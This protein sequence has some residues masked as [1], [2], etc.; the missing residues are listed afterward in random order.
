MDDSGKTI[1][2]NICFVYNTKIE[3]SGKRLSLSLFHEQLKLAFSLSLKP[4]QLFSVGKCREGVCARATLSMSIPLPS[5]DMF[6]CSCFLAI[7]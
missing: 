3:I 5:N 1:K 7:R 4:L 2:F 6:A